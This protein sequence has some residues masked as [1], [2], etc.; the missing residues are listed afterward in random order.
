[1]QGEGALPREIRPLKNPGN[2]ANQGFLTVKVEMLDKKHALA[3]PMVPLEPPTYD[4]FELRV[5]VWDAVDV[6]AKDEAFFG[7]GGTSDV[8]ITCQPIGKEP[9]NMQKTDVHWRSPGDAEFN[10]RMVWPMALPEKSPRLFVQIWDSVRALG[11]NCAPKG[12]PTSV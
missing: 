12:A 3:N 10:W 4:M 2:A 11:S 6:K 5:I 9:Y 1:M 7:G 8:F